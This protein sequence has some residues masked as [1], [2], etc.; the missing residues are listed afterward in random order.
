MCSISHTEL[1]DLGMKWCV[2]CDTQGTEGVGE[3]TGMVGQYYTQSW[4]R[5]AE[6]WGTAFRVKY[7]AG[8]WRRR[9]EDRVGVTHR[10]GGACRCDTQGWG[11]MSLSHT[12]VGSILMWHTGLGECVQHDTQG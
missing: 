10:T 12:G 2:Q 11:S 5:G 1:G 4:R 8:E 3:R 9:L 6:D 7:M